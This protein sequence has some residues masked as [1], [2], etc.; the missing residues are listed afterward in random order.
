MLEQIK[1]KSQIISLFIECLTKNNS[2]YISFVQ[3]LIIFI[4][5]III[6]II[7]LM[8]KVFKW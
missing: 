2:I 6:L 3:R 7:S 4:I 8:I 5:F 1:I